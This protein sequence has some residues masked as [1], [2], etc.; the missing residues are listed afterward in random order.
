MLTEPGLRSA[1]AGVCQPE[2]GEPHVVCSLSAC[3]RVSGET[4][5]RELGYLGD[6]KVLFL[7]WIKKI[8]SDECK[9]AD[10]FSNVKRDGVLVCF[11]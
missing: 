11:L 7:P 3:Y 5:E 4:T 8:Q 1:S 6:V 2:F 9:S 10:V